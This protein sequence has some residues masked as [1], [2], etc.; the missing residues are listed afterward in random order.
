MS[1][2]RQVAHFKQEIERNNKMTD[3][4]P[5][6]EWS[7]EVGQELEDD[8][9]LTDAGQGWHR[10]GKTK[11]S[12][13]K[14]IKWDGGV[15]VEI[16]FEDWKKVPAS[17]RG[18]EFLFSVDIAEFDAKAKE[19]GWDYARRVQFKSQDWFKILVPSFETVFGEDSMNAE[20]FMPTIGKV[21]DAYVDWLDVTQSPKKDGTIAKNPNTDKPYTT[22]QLV[23]V[24]ANQAEAQEAYSELH[25]SD[26]NVAPT[27]SPYPTIWHNSTTPEA[28]IAHGKKIEQDYEDKEL[29]EELQITDE[30]KAALTPDGNEVD[31]SAI[32]AKIRPNEMTNPLSSITEEEVPF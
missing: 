7:D 12:L 5:D 29:A 20:N 30:G 6:V 8:F 17:K 21:K 3:Q 32:I 1:A 27:G 13:T 26:N 24:F 2:L 25:T 31:V 11:V 4:F 9:I 19:E 15:A 10:I 23:K 18:H 22:L 14:F 28:M 16:S